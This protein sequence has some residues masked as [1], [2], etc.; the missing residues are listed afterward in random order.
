[1]E[2]TW[3]CQ[4][5]TPE[6]TSPFDHWPAVGPKVSSL[7]SL[8]LS[9]LSCKQEGW[10]LPHRFVVRIKT[11][12]HPAYEQHA[13]VVNDCISSYTQQHGALTLLNTRKQR[14]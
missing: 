6:F 3:A 1:M 14:A 4:S 10:S 9:F 7:T 8:S 12:K 11:I 2:V 5:D 13:V